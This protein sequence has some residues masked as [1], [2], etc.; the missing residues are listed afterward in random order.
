MAR[1]ALDVVL[2]EVDAAPGVI[3]ELTVIAPG[4]VQKE[5]G[6]VLRLRA[7]RA[8]PEARRAPPARRAKKA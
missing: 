8:V 7:V 5:L 6:E 4:T 1:R 2:A 3:D